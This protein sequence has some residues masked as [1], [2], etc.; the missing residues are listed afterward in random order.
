M[1]ISFDLNNKEKPQN[2]SANRFDS[3]N[4]IDNKLN[5]I[6]NNKNHE[7]SKN[8]KKIFS[9]GP[10]IR[11][12][13]VFSFLYTRMWTIARIGNEPAGHGYTQYMGKLKRSPIFMYK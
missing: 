5:E 11:P 7:R 2:K 13:L 12:F 6:Q 4:R 3:S 10:I 9:L 1:F 8:Q